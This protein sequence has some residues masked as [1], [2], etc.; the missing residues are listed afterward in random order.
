[1]SDP[2]DRKK[3]PLPKRPAPAAGQSGSARDIGAALGG[4]LDFE[5]DALLDSLLE[6]GP[7]VEEPTE[8]SPSPDDAPPP[9]SVPGPALHKPEDR[10]YPEDE[11]TL[12]ES[13]P[14]PDAGPPSIPRPDAPRPPRPGAPPD[15]TATPPA[16]NPAGH[17]PREPFPPATSPVAPQASA[18]PE[19]PRSPVVDVDKPPAQARMDVDPLGRT[20]QK[21]GPPKADAD[22]DADADPLAKTVLPDT[23]TPIPGEADELDFES[24]R[25]PSAGEEP[26]QE[27]AEAVD[28]DPTPE[29]TSIDGEPS[30]VDPLEFEPAS[31]VEVGTEEGDADADEP[32]G[33]GEPSEE[34]KDGE[35]PDAAPQAPAG[36]AWE[37]ER[38]CSAHLEDQEA[39]DQF[40]A[41]AD[42]LQS[43]AQAMEDADRKSRTLL[44]AS[45]LYAMAGDTARARTAA[46]AAAKGTP[47]AAVAQRQ[48]RWLAAQEGDWKA[49]AAALEAEAR[50]SPTVESRAHG[51]Y[52]SSEIHRIIT[53][54]EA[55]AMRKLEQ[56]ARLLPSDPRAPV[57]KLAV[58]LGKS[59]GP[60]KARWPDHDAIEPFVRATREISRLRAPAPP[61]DETTS[62]PTVDFEDA[63]RALAAGDRSNAGAAIARL[64][65]VEGLEA[66]AHWLAA[67]L[68][69]HDGGTRSQAI[70]ELRAL[71]ARGDSR[72]ARR[73]L[74]ARALEQ[75]DAQAVEAAG[76]PPDSDEAGGAP[77]DA[78]TP[79]D[80]VALGALTR[81]EPAALSPWIAQI[82]G[83]DDLRPLCAA[84]ASV[85]APAGEPTDVVAGTDESQ[86]RVAIGR[87]LAS[88]QLGDR[89]RSALGALS[90]HTED[91]PLVR[92]LTLE[93]ALSE[94][95]AAD[96]ARALAGWRGSDDDRD[97]QLASAFV[98]EIANETDTARSQYAAALG[99]EASFEAA[100]RALIPSVDPQGASGLLSS[101]ARASA[102]EAQRS[103]LLVEAALRKGAQD[104]PDGFASLLREAAEA[105]PGLPFAYAQGELLSRA[106]GNAEELL[107]WLRLRRDAATDEI[108]KAHDLVREALLVADDDT[109]N[110]AALLADATRAR[111]TDV[112]LRELHERLS[113][114]DADDRGIWREAA[115]TDA[116]ASGKVQLLVEAALEFERQGD[117]DGAARAAQA[118]VDA[119]GDAFA[120]AT[121]ERT[122]AQSSDAARL[123]ET[124]LRRAKEEED[125]DQQCELYERLSQLDDARGDAASALLWR[126]VILETKPDH[127]PSL[128]Y[129]EHAFAG[130]GRLDD[131]ET[132][133]ASLAEQLSDVE[134][135][136]HSM[137]AAR[138]RAKTSQWA[139]AR[140]FVELAMKRDEPSLWALRAWLAHARSAGDDAAQLDAAKR[141][142]ART[143]H[144]RD[145]ATL[146]LRAAEAA[147]RLGSFDEARELLDKLNELAPSHLKGLTTR[148]RTLAASGDAEGAAEA[149]EALAQVSAVDEHRLDAWYQA[150]LLW[151][152]QVDNTE[153][154]QLALEHAA[155]IDVTREEVFNRLQATYVAANDSTKLAD[156]L[157]RRLAE[158]SDP[159]ERV[160]LEV[161]RGRALAEVGEREAAKLALAAALDAN[162]D[163]V[164]ALDAF[165]DLCAAEGDWEGAEQSWIRLARQSQEP[166]LQAEMYRKLGE[167][168]ETHLTNPERAELAYK[169]ILKR[170]PNDV[171]AKERLVHVYGSLGRPDDAVALQTELVSQASAPEEKRARM[172][173]LATVY[174]QIV[175]DTKKAESTLDRARKA[176][177]QSGGVLKALAGFYQR[178]SEG[179]ALQVL[180][181][182]AANDA[183]RALNTGRF[184]PSFFEIL[185]TVAELRG[186]ADAAQIAKATLAALKGE[187]VE[188]QGAGVAAADTKLDDLLAPELLSGPLRS[189]LRKAGAALDA[190]YPVDLKALRASPMPAQAAEVV[191]QFQQVAGAFGVN[192]LDIFVSSAL[193]AVCMPASSNPPQLVFGSA[194]LE[195]DDDAVRSFLF[196]RAVKILQ[197]HAA[198][199]A[200]TAP[201]DLW[202]V[203][204]ALLRTFAPDWQPAGVDARKLAEAE[205]RIKRTLPRQLDD[206]VAVLAL[207]VTGAIGNRAS[208][209]GTAINEIG[210][211]TALL[212]IGDPNTAIRG[213]A[214]AGGHAE[215]PPES[216]VDRLKWI[217]RNPEARDIAVFSVSDGYSEARR[218]L[219]LSG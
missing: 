55:G 147:A 213:I 49:V 102:D 148:A 86:S 182:R 74:A 15:A 56:V 150:A 40:V 171:G 43:E 132:V 78:F 210:N 32:A 183:R 124:L 1:M 211:R 201:I 37:D 208:Q 129:L 141:I 73:A 207:E 80:R 100:A 158:T 104:D 66:G 83:N 54:D 196:V 178:T 30:E 142:V 194:L 18:A 145:A 12:L 90:K 108:E 137:L 61:K 139:D 4:D 110:A 53:Q 131:L 106:R 128:R 70:D 63:R 187:E 95:S 168:Y 169:E 115:A 35:A 19:G 3:P 34:Q 64:A 170:Q 219:G 119:G 144:E 75:G 127:L 97:S 6:D 27:E 52:L 177:P 9:S 217:V 41:R 163:H 152:E 20:I 67:S 149:F 179:A 198:A 105:H 72:D 2:P 111:P 14:A 46:T 87:A 13:V 202:P 130:A 123:A 126:N 48:A 138:L 112:A 101:T 212:A 174:E 25:A 51:V 16:V 45:E 134:A 99:S 7:L 172:V 155:D 193:G 47:T 125:P 200:R 117:V 206:D 160:A 69:A 84:S 164:D 121:A 91:D 92:L 195:S 122:A 39:R 42:W 23:P 33:A 143:T 81:G 157:E 21:P 36:A 5:P 109:D 57:F 173:A 135:T 79:A 113:S 116:V 65:K 107:A 205:A 165:A 58:Q 89:F 71:I 189:L 59:A 31:D 181:D 191:A 188:I 175:G 161:T 94:K 154:G 8:G 77:G 140:P 96:V 162:P 26:T 203:T 93:I 176:W 24:E 98:N 184:D 214:L 10:A 38:P 60:P 50:S 68:L 136:A 199:L 118:A 215:G 204:A 192:N 209:L 185:G 85:V 133:A 216:G 103:L 29:P 44:V 28:S 62:S 166:E 120:Q 151:L 180:L 11:V 82:A 186:G 17:P 159:D 22:A 76:A 197:A 146:T 88:G 114:A 190:A 153:R 167:L 218:R 156:L